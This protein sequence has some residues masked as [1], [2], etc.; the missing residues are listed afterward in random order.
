LPLGLMNLGMKK[1]TVFLT[2]IL[3]VTG[4]AWASYLSS[5]PLER[6]I[7]LSTPTLPLDQALKA[8]EAE[9]DLSFSYNPEKFN[10]DRE[11]KLEYKR[12]PVRWIL[13]D[14]FQGN[15]KY[16]SRGKYVVLRAKRDLHQELPPP[17]DI[18]LSGYILDATTGT[19]VPNVTLF[20]SVSLKSTLSNKHGHFEFKLHP[21]TEKVHFLLRKEGYRDTSFVVDKK[22]FRLLL[23]GIQP[24]SVPDEDSL[25]IPLIEFSEDSTGSPIDTLDTKDTV[26]YKDY[27]LSREIP[28][29]INA[30]KD[31]LSTEFQQ[32]DK[33]VSDTFRRRFQ[34]SFLPALGTNGL[35]SGQVINDYSFNILGGYSGGNRVFELGGLFNLNNGPVSGVQIGGLFNVVNGPVSGLQVGGLFNVSETLAGTAIGGIVNIADEVDGVQ[36]AGI[37]NVAGGSRGVQIGGLFNSAY[38]HQGVQL[39][40]LVNIARTVEGS[41]IGLI[42][43]SD[44]LRGVGLGFFTFVKTGYHKLEVGY[45]ELTPYRI[46][47]RTGTRAFHNIFTFGVNDLRTREYSKIGYGLG[48]SFKLARWLSLDL[49]L[50]AYA[51]QGRNFNSDWQY[52]NGNG[53]LYL[54]LDIHLFKHLSISAGPTAN[55]YAVDRNHPQYGETFSQLR[56]NYQWQGDLGDNMQGFS[57][58]GFRT[59][60]RFF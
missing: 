19:K 59:A 48:T 28:A 51:L 25:Q 9:A 43:I 31:W 36:L 41:Q 20:D 46:S 26:W 37:G 55:F 45:D 50:T 23:I 11:V 58:F 39:A 24:L 16:K 47:F 32:H 34:V 22:G 13:D 2:A 54:G 21:K 7:S 33:N 29:A 17:E 52:F 10:M 3:A 27:R 15:V 38:K 44:T 6:V 56:P 5:A 1:T 30:I 14:V 35:M 42:N 8:I 53:E 4:I 49:D 60:I 57:W 12:R 40:G 18:H